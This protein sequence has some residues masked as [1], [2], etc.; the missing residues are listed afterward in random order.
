MPKFKNTNTTFWLIFKQCEEEGMLKVNI[1]AGL[2]ISVSSLVGRPK[3]FYYPLFSN[4]SKLDSLVYWMVKKKNSYIFSILNPAEKL[5]STFLA[6]AISLKVQ[7]SL[8]FALLDLMGGHS[9]S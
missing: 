8:V 7:N 1:K 3:T 5:Q 6:N 4:G 9:P 2:E